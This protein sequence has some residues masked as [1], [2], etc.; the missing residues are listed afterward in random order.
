MKNQLVNQSYK[1]PENGSKQNKI[2]YRPVTSLD[3][4]SKIFE[5]CYLNQLLDHVNKIL[6]KYI[7]AYRKGHSYQ[8]V[9]MKLTEEWRE[10]LDKNKVVGACL[11]ISQKHSTAYHMIY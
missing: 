6:S 11:L 3:G 2:H 5:K 1:N 9:L 4:F 7:S 10:N 8:N